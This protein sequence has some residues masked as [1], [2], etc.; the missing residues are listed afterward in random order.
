MKVS[1]SVTCVELRSDRQSKSRKRANK[2]EQ[3]T[4]ERKA[5]D[6]QCKAKWRVKLIKRLLSLELVTGSVRLNG[7]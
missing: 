4:V 5:S 1:W 2:T 6:R 7:E 3:E